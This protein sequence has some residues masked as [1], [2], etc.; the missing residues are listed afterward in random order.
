MVDVRKVDDAGD[1]YVAT[2]GVRGSDKVESIIALL[3]AN[4]DMFADIRLVSESPSAGAPGPRRA[5][6]ELRLQ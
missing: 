5:L 3:K 2:L 6:I 4:T 1:G